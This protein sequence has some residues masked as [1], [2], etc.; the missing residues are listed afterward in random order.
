M[1]GWRDP[2]R[3]EFFR[4]VPSNAPRAAAMRGMRASTRQERLRPRVLG[5]LLCASATD[6]LLTRTASTAGLE[7]TQAGV[8]A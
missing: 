4:L 1:S 6:G 7:E 8:D 5:F 3:L 2:D